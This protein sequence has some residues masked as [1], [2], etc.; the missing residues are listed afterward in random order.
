MS[1][2]SSQVRDPLRSLWLALLLASTPVAAIQDPGLKVRL[3]E[4]MVCHRQQLCIQHGLSWAVSGPFAVSLRDRQPYME[5][6]I[7]PVFRELDPVSHL[8]HRTDTD[9]TF[10]DST[11]HV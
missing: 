3:S 7:G 11:D 6:Q 5:E 1:L 8:L 9:C 4:R 2:L 10:V